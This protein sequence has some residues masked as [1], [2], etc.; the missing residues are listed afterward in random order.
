[1]E[2]VLGEKSSVKLHIISRIIFLCEIPPPAPMELNPWF[3]KQLEIRPKAKEGK[4]YPRLVKATGDFFFTCNTFDVPL[5][6]TLW[7][8][9]KVYWNQGNY[10]HGLEIYR[11]LCGSYS[12]FL[13]MSFFLEKIYDLVL[14]CDANVDELLHVCKAL[15]LT[16]GSLQKSHNALSQLAKNLRTNQWPRLWVGSPRLAA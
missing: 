16:W 8:R 10:F 9:S 7:A 11:K 13:N 1:M 6:P 15:L 4:V 14:Q 2:K 12:L 5:D 3:Q